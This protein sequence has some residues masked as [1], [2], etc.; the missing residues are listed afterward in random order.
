MKKLEKRWLQTQGIITKF[1]I[2]CLLVVLVLN[3]LTPVKKTSEMENRGLAQRPTLSWVTLSDG[4]FFKNYQTF[5]SDQ[6][7]ARNGWI[8]LNYLMQKFSGV[9]KIQDVY[10]CHDQL[11]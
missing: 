1:F 3:V 9:R 4:S 2:V 6:F 5:E 8:H 11:M 10:L 7:V